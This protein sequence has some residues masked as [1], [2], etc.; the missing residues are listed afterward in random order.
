MIPIWLKFSEDART[1]LPPNFLADRDSGHRVYQK[2]HIPDP[3]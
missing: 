1:I 2:D 3:Q